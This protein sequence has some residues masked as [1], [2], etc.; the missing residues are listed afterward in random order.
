MSDPMEIDPVEECVLN[1]V[2][3][4][5][6]F[7][8]PRTRLEIGRFVRMMTGELSFSLVGPALGP[9]DI[10]P[11]VTEAIASLIKKG[12]LLILGSQNPSYEMTATGEK[13]LEGARDKWAKVLTPEVMRD[14]VAGMYSTNK[15]QSLTETMGDQDYIGGLINKSI[16]KGYA[17]GAEALKT[18]VLN[19][20]KAEEALCNKKKPK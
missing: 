8:N 5:A 9:D 7:G 18:S 2:F 3:A 13:A 14:L 6:Q 17:A 4:L 20:G 15:C 10:K 11:E 12:C 1:A 16:D 19:A